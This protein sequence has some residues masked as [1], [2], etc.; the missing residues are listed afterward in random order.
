MSYKSHNAILDSG[1]RE[2]FIILTFEDVS[3]IYE[4]IYHFP[5]KKVLQ[6]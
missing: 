3:S 1:Y 5:R 2:N 4:M 6:G